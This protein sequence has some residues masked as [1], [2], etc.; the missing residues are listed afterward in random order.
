MAE[1]APRWTARHECPDFQVFDDTIPRED[2]HNMYGG[3]ISNRMALDANSGYWWIDNGE[4]ASAIRFCP[5]C[6]VE[7]ATLERKEAP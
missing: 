5:W 1:R 3:A 2:Y 6:G 4:Y 7:L